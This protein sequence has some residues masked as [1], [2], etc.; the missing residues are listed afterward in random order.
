MRRSATTSES[1]VQ[2]QHRLGNRRLAVHPQAPFAFSSRSR[3]ALGR[4]GHSTS[5]ARKPLK[6]NDRLIARTEL[7]G[8]FTSTAFRSKNLPGPKPATLDLSLWP[9]RP[10]AVNAIHESQNPWFGRRTGIPVKSTG[11]RKSERTGFAERESR[12]TDHSSRIT[13]R[14]SQWISARMGA[15]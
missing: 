1:A 4:N 3:I 5:T 9:G 13:A 12:I 2:P 10:A 14:E 7:P 15:L 8:A 11:P 6:T